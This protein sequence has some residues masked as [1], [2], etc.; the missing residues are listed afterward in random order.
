M[1]TDA[2]E[3]SEPRRENAMELRRDASETTELRRDDADAGIG[4]PGLAPGPP[5]HPCDSPP[6]PSPARSLDTPKVASLRAK[7]VFNMLGSGLSGMGSMG[8]RTACTC[9]N[10]HVHTT[11][12]HTDTQTHRHTQSTLR[13]AAPPYERQHDLPC[14]ISHSVS[15]APLGRGGPIHTFLFVSSQAF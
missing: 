12:K 8:P 5:V 2:C 4:P 6:S 14:R 11:D 15:V 3:I 10:V 13:P 9:T 7:D 1:Q